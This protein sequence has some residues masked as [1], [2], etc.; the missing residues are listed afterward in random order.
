MRLQVWRLRC[1][2]WCDSAAAAAFQAP[3]VCLKTRGVSH[4]VCKRQGEKAGKPV[5]QSVGSV[6]P[7]DD[8]RPGV[9]TPARSSC[10]CC[11]VCA[12]MSSR[13]RGQSAAAAGTHTDSSRSLCCQQQQRRSDFRWAGHSLEGVLCVL[14]FSASLWSIMP[15]ICW[16]GVF[17][18]DLVSAI[19]DR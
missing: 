13:Q 17:T 8:P 3:T 6:S 10:C 2:W 7:D 11:V 12:A 14:M 16:G 19:T 15:L 5:S 9:C 18:S 1:V 4:K